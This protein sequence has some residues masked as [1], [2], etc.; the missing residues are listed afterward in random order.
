MGKHRVSKVASFGL[1]A[2]PG[3]DNEKTVRVCLLWSVKMLI[4]EQG[5]IK[6]IHSHL[7]AYQR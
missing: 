5:H 4:S 1:S 6:Y 3:K 7:M 2:M